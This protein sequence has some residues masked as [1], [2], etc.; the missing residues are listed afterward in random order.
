[1]NQQINKMVNITYY[2]DNI[3]CANSDKNFNG[4][5]GS[6]VRNVLIWTCDWWY[7][8]ILTLLVDF[9]TN[10]A[11]HPLGIN[12]SVN[13]CPHIIERINTT[14]VSV[15]T[16]IVNI[17]FYWLLHLLQGYNIFYLHLN[18]ANHTGL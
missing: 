3:Q 12:Q 2:K 5:I 8:P 16:I 17:R 15:S 7:V 14:A 4:H 18:V 6:R 10:K 13:G 1:M 11:Y 9:L